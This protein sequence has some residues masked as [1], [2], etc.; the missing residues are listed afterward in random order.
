[1]QA[2]PIPLSGLLPVESSAETDNVDMFPGSIL[3]LIR[4]GNLAQAEMLLHIRLAREPESAKTFNSLGW[5]A[6][7]VNLPLFATQYFGE[8]IR[9]APNWSTPRRNLDIVNA[10]LKL[11]NGRPPA[12]RPTSTKSMST[13]RF[14]LIKAWGFGFWADVGHVLGQLLV[15]ELTERIAVVHW[16]RNSLF[17]H[18]AAS[19]SFDLFF[20][21][22][23]AATAF[24][25][26]Q[27]ES[28]SVW[29]PKWNRNNLTE[30]EV[31]KW[32]G[33]YSR[34][35]ALYLLGRRERVVVSDFFTSV[36][37][38]KPWI[39]RESHLYRMSVD[40]LWRYLIRK[41]LHPK[42]EIIDAVN[43]FYTENLGSP[44]YV[45]VH[46]RGSDKALEMRNLRQTNLDYQRAISDLRAAAGSQRI[47]LMTDDVKL[48]DYYVGLYGENVIF[49]DCQRTST[50]QGIHY[51]SNRDPPQLGKEVMID[52][53]LAIKGT[54]FVGNGYSNPSQMVLYLRPWPED[55]IRLI[56]PSLYNSPLTALH[57]W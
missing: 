19:S 44:D 42:R 8:A 38:I 48:K 31:N 13:E 23:S 56:G 46:A 25:L 24:D 21:P 29:P 40:D 37:D 35:A 17:W 11:D 39:P 5:I 30:G 22:I 18:G 51:Q 27:I 20:E 4:K 55:T 3:G 47:F 57:D 7:A 52:T 6:A 49:T 14:L 45:S 28:F 50:G 41:Y 2:S 32:Q 16:G 1:M 15:A 53:Y 34:V 36:Y 54:A 12:D 43:K 26:S 9:L 10:K 33:P